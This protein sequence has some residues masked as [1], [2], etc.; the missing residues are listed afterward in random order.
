L[1]TPEKAFNTEKTEN[2]HR[3]N[4]ERLERKVHGG[5]GFRNDENG[6]TIEPQISNPASLV[7]STPFSVSSV[8]KDFKGR[9]S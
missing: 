9:K 6:K 8:L 7:F 1:D 5:R 3:E 4:Q 2:G